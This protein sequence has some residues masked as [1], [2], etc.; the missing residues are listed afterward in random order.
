[1]FLAQSPIE[2]VLQVVAE[3]PVPPRRLQ[4]KVPRD[5]ETICLKCLQKSPAR[6]YASA[7]ALA[8]DLGR[9]LAGSPTLGGPVGMSDRLRNW[10]RRR[11]GGAAAVAVGVAA[12]GVLLTLSLAY[13]VRLQDE[14]DLQVKLRKE[15]TLQR[16]R[17]EERLV[18][19]YV[20]TG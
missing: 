2:T 5:L 17:A 3:D 6:R 19:Q 12:V 9:F 20:A 10:A 13:N 15:E 14:R 4:P 7:R 16:Q 1:P 8:E 11:P 18:R